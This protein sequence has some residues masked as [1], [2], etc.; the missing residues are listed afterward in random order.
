M[1]DSYMSAL[2]APMTATSGIRRIAGNG[3]N[4]T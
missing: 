4:G 2:T 3:A 1:P